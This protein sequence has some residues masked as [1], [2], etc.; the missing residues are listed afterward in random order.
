MKRSNNKKNNNNKK[1]KPIALAPPVMRSR[2]RARQVTT[3]FHRL[4]RQVEAARR[5]GDDSRVGLLEAELREMGG[6]AE[7]QRASQ[8][9]TS[10]FSPCST[11]R[12]AGSRKT[13]LPGAARAIV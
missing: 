5:E 13:N 4:T 7:Y 11:M 8:V 6:R 9:S 3:K 2:K 10:F 1:K 12:P